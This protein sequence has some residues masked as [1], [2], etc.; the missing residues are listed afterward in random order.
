M[1]FLV[2]AEAALL[3]RHEVIHSLWPF[4]GQGQVRGWRSVPKS[5]RQHP[6]SAV[7]WTSLHAEQLP[8]LLTNLVDLIDR[9][10]QAELWSRHRSRR[11]MDQ[12][13]TS[14]RA[15]WSA[16]TRQRTE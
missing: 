9:C 14:T 4:T 16:V 12:R 1:A 2:D 8:D 3:E 15:S 6:A 10:R 13:H 5:R 11:R 7:N